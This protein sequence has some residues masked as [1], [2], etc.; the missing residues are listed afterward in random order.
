[1]KREERVLKATS[2]LK[3]IEVRMGHGHYT[4]GHTLVGIMVD[5]RSKW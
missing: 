4:S 2:I 5:A 3:T 1:M